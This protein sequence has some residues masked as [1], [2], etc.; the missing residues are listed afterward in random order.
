M[1]LMDVEKIK[2]LRKE[3]GYNN[4]QELSKLLGFGSA[5]IPRWESGMSSMSKSHGLMVEAFLKIPSFREFILSK[6]GIDMF[7]NG[8]WIEEGIIHISENEMKNFM[9]YFK[10]KTNADK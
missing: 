6:N 3:M 7:E 4:A 10:E 9:N 8:E 2:S 5:T 1:N